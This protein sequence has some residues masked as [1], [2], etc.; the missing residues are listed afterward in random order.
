MKPDQKAFRLGSLVL[1]G[2][3]LIRLLSGALDTAAQSLPRTEIAQCL[4]FFQTGRFADTAALQVSPADPTEQTEATTEPTAPRPAAVT[5]APEDEATVEFRNATDL[6]FDPTDLLSRPLDWELTGDAPTVLIFHTHGTE[7]YAGTTGYRSLNE[8]ENM[9]AIGDRLADRLQEQGICVLHDRTLHDD[10]SYNGSY[11]LARQTIE[12]YLARYPTIRLVLDIHRDAAED[13]NGEQ[14]DYT[15]ATPDGSAA[16]LMLVMGTND[17]G[18]AHPAWQENLALAAQLQVCLEQL[19]PDICR[20][21]YVRA[22]RF[23]QD[24]SPG[25][26]LVEV[27]AAGNTLEEALLATDI[28]ARG[29]LVLAHGANIPS[30]P[31]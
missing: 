10:V 17:G 6:T 14:I 11:G 4:L 31:L 20:P 13:A 12:Q 16:K 8:K 19:C 5:F 15:V 25:A 9:L 2:A 30:A 21:I 23:N 29:I 22:S 26:L 28:L 3:V 18:L 7:S 27:G 24:L 1:I